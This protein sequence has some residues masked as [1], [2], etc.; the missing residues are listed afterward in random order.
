MTAL[1]SQ[2]AFMAERELCKRSFSFFVKRAWHV[3]EASTPLKWGWAMD[4]MCDHLQAVTEGEIQNLLINV[5][6]GT[7]K[8][9]LSSVFWPAWEWGPRN[10]PH[11]RY[12]GVA[13]EFGYAVRDSLKMRDLLRSDWFSE[14][15]KIDIRK[16]LDGKHNFGNTRSGIRWA[17]TFQNITGA[18]GNRVIIDDPIG[19]EHANSKTML[20]R[21]ERT[22]RETLPMRVND[23]KKD[24]FIVIMQRLHELDPSGV[25]LSGDMGYEH[26]CIPME[27]EPDRRCHTS[28]GWSDPRTEEGELMFPERFPRDVV[29]KLKLQLQSYGTAG[30]LQQRPSPRG[31]G[32]LKESWWGWWKVRPRILWRRIYV[33]TAQKEGEENDYS[34][35]QCWGMT[36]TGQIALLDQLRG[37]WEAPDLDRN[38]RQF[39]AKHRAAD[40]VGPLQVIKVED[41]VSGTGLIQALKRPQKLPN[42]GVEPAIPVNDIQ[43]NRDK[44]S[45]A[46][47]AAPQIEA[48][49]VLLPFDAPWVTDYIGEANDFP[50]GANDDQMDPT[51]D[52][53]EDMLGG[54]VKRPAPVGAPEGALGPSLVE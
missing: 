45:R 51:F 53:I 37:K 46:Y 40:G 30:Q 42:G 6:P 41:K 33:D 20:K 9:L 3:L 36:D 17:R 24:S 54:V 2:D 32:I 44:T 25:I 38:T 34:V 27:F 11:Y 16:D 26:L 43:R 50:A 49:N 1:T 8:S 28:I 39:W 5:P 48:G 10:M 29:E 23:L 22:I 4:A 52:A 13:H 14:R 35:L 19:V 7:S 47:S 12:V 15:W 31:G 21:G 18:R